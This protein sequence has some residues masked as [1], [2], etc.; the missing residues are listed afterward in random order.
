[1]G[2]YSGEGSALGSLFGGAGSVIGGLFGGLFNKGKSEAEKRAEEMQNMAYD[3]NKGQTDMFLK[4][5]LPGYMSALQGLLS[6][7]GY[8]PL[9]STVE[10][11]TVGNGMFGSQGGEFGYGG[12]MAQQ[13]EATADKWTQAKRLLQQQINSGTIPPSVG[14]AAMERLARSEAME[15]RSAELNSKREGAAQ[16]LQ[17][18]APA[19]GMGTGAVNSASQGVQNTMGLVNIGKAQMP[20]FSGIGSYIGNFL[21]PK[22]EA[23]KNPF[24]PESSGADSGV[25]GG[26]LHNKVDTS[27]K[28]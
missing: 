18:L 7:Y 9:G 20:D 23:V 26:D 22:K 16:L 3:V 8:R 25:Y 11:S 4:Y 12:A 14:A 6:S 24:I 17:F 5:G 13:F 10:G 21:S 15:M 2:D 19:L 1:M 28:W 27:F